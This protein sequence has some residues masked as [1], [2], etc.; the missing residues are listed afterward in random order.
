MHASP[1]NNRCRIL[2][3]PARADPTANKTNEPSMTLLRPHTLAKVPEG[4]NRWA[5]SVLGRGEGGVEG[6]V[7]LDCGEG[8]GDGGLE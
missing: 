3:R 1:R 4:G 8:G 2:R 6:E 5:V 7:V